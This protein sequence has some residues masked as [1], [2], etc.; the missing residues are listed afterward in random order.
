MPLRSA[1]AE[2]NYLTPI[3]VYKEKRPKYRQEPRAYVTPYGQVAEFG[4][5]AP[6]ATGRPGGLYVLDLASVRAPDCCPLEIRAQMFY[7]LL[8]GSG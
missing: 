2:N 7:V 8:G 1:E 4:R 3:R 5:V 6:V